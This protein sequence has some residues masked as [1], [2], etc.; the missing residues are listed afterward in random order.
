MR[1][2]DVSSFEFISENAQIQHVRK[3]MQL[4]PGLLRG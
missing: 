4:L 1:Q 3:F 2:I